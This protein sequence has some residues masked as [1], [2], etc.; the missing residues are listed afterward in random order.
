MYASGLQCRQTHVPSRLHLERECQR[1]IQLMRPMGRLAPDF[2]TVVDFRRDNGP[3]YLSFEPT[4]TRT[5]AMR[6]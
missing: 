4:M 3:S 6:L 5:A 1:N 2:T